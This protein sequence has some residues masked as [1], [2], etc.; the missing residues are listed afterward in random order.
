MTKHSTWIVAPVF[1]V[2]IAA[3]SY[4][5]F[6]QQLPDTEIPVKVGVLAPLT[7]NFAIFGERIR[8]AI[9]LAKA[10][11]G[12]KAENFEIIY[13]GACQPEETVTAVQKLLSVDKVSWF[14]GSFC[15]IGLVPVISLVQGADTFIFNIATNPDSTLNQPHVFSTNKSVKA[16]A[17]ALAT[18][19]TTELQAK[20]AASFHYVTPLGED[21]GKYFFQYFTQ[22]GRVVLSD[23]KI[24]LDAS[25]F[26]TELIKM[27]TLNPD[28]IF[29]IHLAQPLGNFIKQAREL[30]I[31]S[32]ILSHSEAEDPNV[33]EVA[34]SAAEGFFISSSEPKTKT[35][36]VR[37]FEKRY[38]EKYSTPPDVIAANA[39]DAFTLQVL[40]WWECNGEIACMENSFRSIKEYA[41]VSGNLTMNPDGSTTKPVLFKVVKNGKFVEIK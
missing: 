31:T 23:Q 8:N 16:D 12:D 5:Y 19:A 6:Q 40:A 37:D 34:G 41:G 27:K 4:F 29:V 30:G 38:Q 3:G 2:L 9:E 15:L 1:I 11:L 22:N 24:Q 14:G 25:D 26:R 28:L 39:Y 10:D 7:G 21:Y 35:S 20:T 18:F 17:E 32:K 13:E 33:L 36:V